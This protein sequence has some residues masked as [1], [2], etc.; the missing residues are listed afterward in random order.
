M[1][2]Q[3]D[4]NIRTMN[5]FIDHGYLTEVNG[6]AVIPQTFGSYE[7][8]DLFKVTRVIRSEGEDPFEKLIT[9]YTSLY[10]RG[11]TVGLLICSTGVAVDFYFCTSVN[12]GGTTAGQFPKLLSGSFPGTA[13]NRVPAGERNTV[14]S[15]LNRP[16]KD[17]AG[18]NRYIASVS[19]V[20]SRRTHE[21]ENRQLTV[22]A[23]GIEKF[24]D[25]MQGKRYTA[26]IFAEPIAAEELDERRS[27]FENMFTMLSPFAKE[28]V[29]YGENES[30]ATNYSLSSNFSKNI[31]S[32]ISHSLGTSHSTSTN[33]SKSGNLSHS[34]GGQGIL[35]GS[36]NWGQGSAW[37]SGTGESD[38][39]SKNTSNTDSTGESEGT[40]TAQGDAHTTGR[41]INI[42]LVREIK[43]VQDAMQ[44]LEAEIKRLSENRSFGMWESCCYVVASDEAT[45][46]I[47]SANLVALFSG[48]ELYS[49]SGYINHWNYNANAGKS[50]EVLNCISHLRHPGFLLGSQT[51]RTSMMVSG[52]DLPV[53]LSMPTRSVMGTEVL[54]KAA[55]G[56]NVPDTF[57]PAKPILFGNVVHMGETEPTQLTFDLNTFASHCFICG[58]AGSGKSNTTY[59]LIRAFH[60]QKVKVLVVEPAKGEYKTVF[61]GMPDTN[62]FTCT[63]DRYRMLYLNPFEFNEEHTNIK[64][65]MDRLNGILQTCWPMF[66]PLPGMIKDAIEESY[67]A[68]GWDLKRSRQIRKTGK[69][70]PTFSDMLDAVVK[71][72][73]ASPYPESSRGDYLGALEMRIRSLMTGFE[74]EIFGQSRGLSDAELFEHNTI[75]DLSSLGNA[76]SRSLIMGILIM[77]LREYRMNTQTVANADLCHV[78][79]L[80]E[81]HNILKRCSKEQN[82]ESSNV[83]GA[84]VQ[85]LTESIAEMRSSG[86]GFLIVDQSPTAV[87]EAAIKNT[88]IKIVM[89]LQEEN[90]CKAMGTALSLQEDQ[91]RELSRLEVGTAAI[92]HAGWSETMLGKMGTVWKHLPEAVRWSRQPEENDPLN[93]KRVR[94]CVAQWVVA[95]FAEDE[96]SSLNAVRLQS[97]TDWLR[98]YQ[99]LRVNNNAVGDLR[100]E[101]EQL[102]TRLRDCGIS[103][104]RSGSARL[105]ASQMIGDY[106]RSL[107]QLDDLF[108]I[109]PLEMPGNYSE[110]EFKTPHDLTKQQRKAIG[111]WWNEIRGCLIEYFH[112]PRTFEGNLLETRRRKPTFA[113]DIMQADYVRTAIL[114]ILQSYDNTWQ[115]RNRGSTRYLDV[116]FELYDRLQDE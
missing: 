15:Q 116:W 38:S 91:I 82:M 2:E 108:R 21:V 3:L 27:G 59:Q 113:A 83:Q 24:I 89:R 70:F 98:T 115:K 90:D 96:L 80:E 45:M 106:L 32:S 29:S 76:D 109:F 78:T 86:E 35:G 92:F 111:S 105:A 33:R 110:I 81:A 54:T 19:V 28:S 51:I 1:V 62:I 71:I 40:G 63:K 64:E 16:P 114:C 17:A 25:S 56:R 47:A 26:L 77:R 107:F 37:S 34:N 112:F 68:C 66:G 7:S 57:S 5:Y 61:A 23:Q 69:R 42:S 100:Q 60:S 22:S 72:I 12:D 6:C 31:S 41:N 14:L 53:M 104:L 101:T 95:A 88:A 18:E 4:R 36:Y 94:S 97:Y 13:L 43:G 73:D 44:R 30:D 10:Y 20:P 84:A 75:V 58:A 93:E 11:C 52:R 46:D 103:S 67:I 85:M 102:L 50:K 99:E 49:S 48:D 9:V 74:E 55:F 8:I 79:V 39:T 87:D 65:H